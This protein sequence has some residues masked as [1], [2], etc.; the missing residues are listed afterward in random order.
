MDGAPGRGGEA[1]WKKLLE[2]PGKA[3]LLTCLEGAGEAEHPVRA[4]PGGPTGSSVTGRATQAREQEG[5]WLEVE[6]RGA[7]LWGL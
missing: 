5:G 3:P 2:V 6:G 1:S 7:G 4:Q